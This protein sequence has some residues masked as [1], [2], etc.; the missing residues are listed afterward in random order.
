MSYSRWC[1]KTVV[2]KRPGCGVEFTQN[3]PGQVYHAKECWKLDY[4]ETAT[5]PQCGKL[6]SRFKIPSRPQLTCGHSCASKYGRA[7]G[8]TNR[9]GKAKPESISFCRRIYLDH[10]CGTSLQTLPADRF[11]DVANGILAGQVVLIR[12][13]GDLPEDVGLVARQYEPHSTKPANTRRTA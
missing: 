7:K 11:V 1:P 12:T 2:C 9:R 3:S 5:C 4:T 8:K 6:F 10:V 13:E